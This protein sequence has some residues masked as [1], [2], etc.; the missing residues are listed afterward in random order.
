MPVLAESSATCAELPSQRHCAPIEPSISPASRHEPNLIHVIIVGGGVAGLILALCLHS[1]GCGAIVL[2]SSSSCALDR[3]VGVSLPPFAVDVLRGLSLLERV[4]Q[5]AC[6]HAG[7]RWFTSAG[8]PVLDVPPGYVAGGGHGL[9]ILRGDLKKILANAVIERLGKDAIVT[10]A[11]VQC[12]E[13]LDDGRRVQVVYKNAIGRSC[14]E[15]GDA[16]VGCDG[17]HSRVRRQLHP[18]VDDELRYAGATVFSGIAWLEDSELLKGIDNRRFVIGGD[19]RQVSLAPISRSHGRLCVHFLIEVRDGTETIARSSVAERSRSQH[20]RAVPKEA[21][22][23]ALGDVNPGFIDVSAILA[24]SSRI[25]AAPLTGRPALAP[26][27]GRGRVT[28][29]GSAASAMPRGA[30]LGGAT[31]SLHDAWVLAEELGRSLRIA[32]DQGTDAV[33]AA[34]ERFERR[35][36]PA[37]GGGAAAAQRSFSELEQRLEQGGS[38]RLLQADAALLQ[39]ALAQ[40]AQGL[41]PPSPIAPERRDET[42]AGCVQVGVSKLAAMAAWGVRRLLSS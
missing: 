7:H 25:Y 17:L 34:L 27:R 31:S 28:L 29:A 16:L 13:E 12:F 10:G 21:V 26:R 3:I 38:R 41:E 33:S 35:R 5:V 39:A 4:E 23:D 9:G 22:L 14:T 1:R 11:R 18:E 2:E 37:P 42:A 36:P 20:G 24:G 8:V 6:V 30:G 32:T 40:A 15:E 19:T